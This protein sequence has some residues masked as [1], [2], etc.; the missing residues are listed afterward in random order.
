MPT[1]DQ[2]IEF[3]NYMKELYPGITFGVASML[4][5][6]NFMYD[7]IKYCYNRKGYE[8]PFMRKAI[9]SS[10]GLLESGIK[11]KDNN[12][13]NPHIDVIMKRLGVKFNKDEII[14]IDDSPNVVNYMAS[15]GYC[16][17]VATKY[18]LIEDWNRG[19]YR[20]DEYHKFFQGKIFE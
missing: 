5:D 6:E 9:V 11:S 1:I 8:T 19:C 4:E 3:T 15:K 7:L 2:I 10:S 20:E 17:I 16:C 14:L 12:D 18:F 13:K